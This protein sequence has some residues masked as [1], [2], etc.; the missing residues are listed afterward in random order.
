METTYYNREENFS[1]YFR[2]LQDDNY[3]D[4]LL[5]E[6]SGGVS[7]VHKQHKFAKQKGVNGLQ[8]NIGCGEEYTR[9]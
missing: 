1:E 5:D 3:T 7:A 4:V 9:D 6:A 2:L 8:N